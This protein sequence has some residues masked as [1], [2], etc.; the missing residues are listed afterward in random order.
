MYA[1]K[2]SVLPENKI[3]KCEIKIHGEAKKCRY[4]EVF[5]I[6]NIIMNQIR[7]I[8]FHGGSEIT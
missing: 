3:S 5:I 7:R 4:D 1:L 2:G 6:H 8:L